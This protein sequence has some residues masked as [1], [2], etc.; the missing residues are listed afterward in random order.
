MRRADSS[1]DVGVGFVVRWLECV[2]FKG[3]PLHILESFQV[4]LPW[5]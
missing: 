1:C 4:P 5:I 2:N 3:K